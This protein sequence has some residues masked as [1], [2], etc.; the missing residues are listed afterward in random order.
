MLRFVVDEARELWA[1]GVAGRL[2][3]C[4]LIGAVGLFIAVCS[5][6]VYSV[7]RTMTQACIA[8]HVELRTGWIQII[9]VGKI[10]VP[11]VHPAGPMQVCDEWRRKD[12]NVSPLP[13]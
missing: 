3:L 13:R 11:I 1:D 7:H 8:Q 4:L 10:M 5:G 6:V 2:I 12:R 9:P